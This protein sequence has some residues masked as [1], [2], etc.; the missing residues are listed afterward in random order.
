MRNMK[1]QKALLCGNIAYFSTYKKKYKKKCDFNRKKRQHIEPICSF[2]ISLMH[3]IQKN[4]MRFEGPSVRGG[5]AQWA[6]RGGL[7]I[8]EF[9]WVRVLNGLLTYW[10]SRLGKV[11]AKKIV[12]K[13][14]RGS[15]VILICLKVA[16]K[17][18]LAMFR[19][20]NVYFFETCPNLA[21]S[22][23][24]CKYPWYSVKFT[25]SLCPYVPFDPENGKF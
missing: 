15:L 18:I 2:C 12:L 4:S 25:Q 6:D 7:W 23:F 17:V 16:K 21:S 14:S 1:T 5:I 8:F 10:M 24:G 11:F 22:K 13:T 20:Q 9:F 19:V 3:F